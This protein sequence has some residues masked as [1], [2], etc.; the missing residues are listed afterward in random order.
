M[1]FLIFS[2]Q[3]ETKGAELIRLVSLE[4]KDE[5]LLN[6]T[7]HSLRISE[8]PLPLS[9]RRGEVDSLNFK[10]IVGVRLQPHL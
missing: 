1:F 4:T 7:P 10:K 2:A 6:L 5:K 3:D 8:T 9:S